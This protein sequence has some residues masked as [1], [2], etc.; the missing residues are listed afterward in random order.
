M[1]EQFPSTFEL[2]EFVSSFEDGSLPASAWNERALAAIAVW[3]L[4]L[5]PPT[6]AM[7]RLELGLE[8]NHLRLATRPA[9]LGNQASSLG[10]VWPHVL[11]HVLGAFGEDDPVAI[12]NRLLEQP[13]SEIRDKAA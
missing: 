2:W 7:R 6:E 5:L 11:R 13:M 4:F 3:Y 9:A 8:R 1:K 12:A 10:E